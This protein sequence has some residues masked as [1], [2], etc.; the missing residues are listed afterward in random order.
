M[1]KG[2]EHLPCARSLRELGL[3][4]LGEEVDSGGL[5]SG[6]LVPMGRLLGRQMQAVDSSDMVVG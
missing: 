2:L 4:Q 5:K 1:V 3:V 6:L